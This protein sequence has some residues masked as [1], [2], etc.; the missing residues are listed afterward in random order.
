MS[1][2]G[3]QPDSRPQQAAPLFDHLVG[4]AEQ[5]YWESQTKRLGSLEIDNQLDLR[6]LFNWQVGRFV[7][8]ENPTGI[9]ASLTVLM[10]L[11]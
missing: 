5:R 9:E 1:E 8:L 2:S 6:G 4:A 10:R 11:T 7:A 3:R